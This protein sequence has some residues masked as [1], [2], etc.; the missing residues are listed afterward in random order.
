MHPLK[1]TLEMKKSFLILSLMTCISSSSMAMDEDLKSFPNGIP[2]KQTKRKVEDD[3]RSSKKASG[4]QPH[5]ETGN[6]NNMQVELN[7]I[8]R[9][10]KKLQSE[11]TFSSLK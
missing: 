10:V 8:E 5:L 11:M 1:R 2:Q 3:E 4:P 9:S 6:L 7:E